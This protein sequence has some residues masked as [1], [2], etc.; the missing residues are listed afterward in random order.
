MKHS[1]SFPFPESTTLVIKTGSHS[2][3]LQTELAI[4]DTEIYQSLNY[5]AAK[6]FKRPLTLLFNKPLI[7][8][9]AKL[10]YAFTT[11][12]IAIDYQTN[13]VKKIQTIYPKKEQGDFIQGFSEYALVVL[14]PKGFC[15]KNKIEEGKTIIKI[16]S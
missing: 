16:K 8:T 9:F 12:L 2:V 13:K 4:S 15:K 1:L 3:K 7:Q 6:D 5:R 11:E 14:A 10:N